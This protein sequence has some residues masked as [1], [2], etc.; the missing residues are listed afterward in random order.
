MN[1]D[2]DGAAMIVANSPGT[3]LRNINTIN[4]FRNLPKPSNGPYPILKFF[5]TLLENVKLNEV[6][7]REICNLVL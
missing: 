2:Y 1:S 7:S 5:F 4:K 3:V 6:E